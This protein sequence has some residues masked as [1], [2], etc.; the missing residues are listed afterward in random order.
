VTTQK[1]GGALS[2]A[3]VIEASPADRA[4]LSA[5]DE[6]V[7]MDGAKINPDE[8][9]KRFD[10]REP[11]ERVRF[12]LFRSGFLRELEVTL[13]RKENVTWA[14]RRLKAP[15]AAQKR[16]YEGWLWTKWESKGP[17]KK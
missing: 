5:R 12:A 4:G 17:K 14:I 16:I 3:S 6:L 2:I 11:G 10:E 7:A 1:Q 15:T 8:W 9:D 13:G